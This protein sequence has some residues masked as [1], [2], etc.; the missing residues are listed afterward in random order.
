MVLSEGSKIVRATLTTTD[1]TASCPGGAHPSMSAA[2]DERVRRRR[3]LSEVGFD[4]E[5]D[6]EA[7]SAI[8]DVAGDRSAEAGGS[9]TSPGGARQRGSE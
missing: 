1:G 3:G 5:Y 4:P 8:G 6:G 2:S 9:H 7:E